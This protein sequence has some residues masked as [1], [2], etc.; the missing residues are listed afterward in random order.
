LTEEQ[1]SQ[2]VQMLTAGL[3]QALAEQAA[4]GKRLDEA[5]ESAKQLTEPTWLG[6]LL[7]RIGQFLSNVVGGFV[8]LIKWFGAQARGIV[9]S[10]QRRPTLCGSVNF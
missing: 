4:L 7:S 2:V 3:V 6:R 8:N 1:A 9:A 10:L 5:I